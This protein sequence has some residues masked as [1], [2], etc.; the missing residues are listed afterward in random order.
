[1][2]K[3]LKLPQKE[4]ENP[5]QETGHGKPV[6]APPSPFVGFRSPFSG[7]VFFILRSSAV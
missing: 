2:V 3:F 6:N 4:M 1:M 7:F 5:K